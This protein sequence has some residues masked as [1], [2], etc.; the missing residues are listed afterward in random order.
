MS[1][2]AKVIEFIPS[3]R[4][5]AQCKP[6]PRY[7]KGIALDTTLGV[8]GPHCVITLPYPAPECGLW[9]VYCNHCDFRIMVTAA[10]RPDDPISI[11]VACF[12]KGKEETAYA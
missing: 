4:G 7:P 5:K 6:D 3:G 11:K 9:D 8:G 12:T 2:P 10:G 1:D